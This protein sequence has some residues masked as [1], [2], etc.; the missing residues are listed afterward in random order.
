MI[1]PISPGP[2]VGTATVDIVHKFRGLRALVIGDAMLDHYLEGTAVRLCKEGPVPVV[3]KVSEAHAPGGAA[4]V[5]ANLAALG[6]E[7]F[8]IGLVGRDP[9]GTLLRSCLRQMGV[10]DRWLVEDA[11]I[12]TLHKIRVLADDQYLVR[13]DEGETRDCSA[14]ARR[15]MLAAVE[16]AFPRCDL[17]VISD[18][19]YGAVTDALIARVR[20]LRGARSCVLAVDSKEIARFARAGATVVTPNLQEAC[21]AVDPIGGGRSPSDRFGAEAVGHRLRSMLDAE[22][23]AVTMAGDGVLLLDRAGA[24][25]HL[26]VHPVPHAGDVGAGDSFTA[27]MALA[28]A[29]G[30][31]A[32]QAARIG[33]DAAAIAITRR[34]TAVVPHQELV[35]RASLDDQ[36]DPLSLKELAT[37]LDAERFAGNR[38]V[39]TNGV[40]DILHAGHVQ[41][42]RRAKALGDVL[43]VGINSDASTRRLKGPSRPINH[44][45]DRLALVSALDSVDY[46]IVFDEETPAE[47]IRALRP[48]I[49]VKG[50]D[51]TVERLPELAAVREVGASIEL[52]SLVEGRSTTS[53]IDRIASLVTGGGLG[54]PL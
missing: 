27:A 6:A 12:E 37:R 5:A 2:P 30:A 40:F 51:Y 50:G 41:L 1:E 18:Y 49:H 11:A 15:Q 38:I 19:A 16:A 43:I 13:F 26:P 35:R 17:V 29:A 23:I 36:A 8:F 31:T 42:L 3:R 32:D 22:H 21:L 52:L 9:A 33:A 53:V 24:L 10:D 4:N 34:R 20:E 54:R 25:R 44:E 48:D 14:A 7:V 39:F 45:R 28:L 47:A 46:A